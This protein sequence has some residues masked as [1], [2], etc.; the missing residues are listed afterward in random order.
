MAV[1][2]VGQAP[3]IRTF[4]IT[5]STRKAEAGD[6]TLRFQSG[7]LE[8]WGEVREWYNEVL[9]NEPGGL[10]NACSVGV[11][12]LYFSA[13]VNQIRERRVRLG[14]SGYC[15]RLE[16]RVSLMQQ[17]VRVYSRVIHERFEP[18]RRLTGV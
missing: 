3:D 2:G 15:L 10:G 12:T 14:Y 6:I 18:R 4:G 1:C 7:P 16:S 8:W 9:K 13:S 17:G 11:V 5:A